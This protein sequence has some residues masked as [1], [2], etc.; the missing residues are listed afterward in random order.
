M[1][2][3]FFTGSKTFQVLGIKAACTWPVQKMALP[4]N[5]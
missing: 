2:A 4:N 5:E 1:V 3:T